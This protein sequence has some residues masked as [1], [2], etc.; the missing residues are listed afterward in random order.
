MGVPRLFPYICQTFPNSVKGVLQHDTAMTIDNLYIDANPIIHVECQHVYNY[1]PNKRLLQPYTDLSSSEKQLLVY[2]RIFNAIIKLVNIVTPT[3]ILFIAIDGTAPVS[4]QNQQRQRRFIATYNKNVTTE[5]TPVCLSPGTI[6]MHNLTQYINYKIRKY[7]NHQY[8]L[9][10]GLIVYFSSSQV[11]GEGEHKIMNF[12]RD[13]QFDANTSHCFY[14]PDADLIMLTLSVHVPIIYL[15]RPNTNGYHPAGIYCDYHIVNMSSIRNELHT[16]LYT[17]EFIEHNLKSKSQDELNITSNDFILIGLFVGND[18]LP[19]IKMFYYLESGIQFMLDAHKDIVKAQYPGL[20]YMMDNKYMINMHKFRLFVEFLSL[21]E[22]D[23]LTEQINIPILDEKYYDTLL[24]DHVD[25]R[26]DARINTIQDLSHIQITPNMQ[27]NYASYRTAYYKKAG[28]EN[29]DEIKKMCQEYLKGIVWVFDYYTNTIPSW[30]WY[31]PYHY[32][33]LMQDFVNVLK[34]KYTHEFELGQ[35]SIPFVQLLSILPKNCIHLLPKTFNKVVNDE[36]FVSHKYYS[37]ELKMDYE[38]KI[39]EYQG[40]C[41]LS[42]V[43]RQIINNV[44]DKYKGKKI[45]KRN[46]LGKLAKF[47]KRQQYKKFTSVY[48]N[49]GKCFVK[50]IEE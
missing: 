7:L 8:S 4:K 9:N 34:S 5:F 3:K 27:L 17:H 37:D 29:E 44:Y 1:G 33:P 35:P 40:I 23:Y 47:S 26:I 38:G 25:Y 12:I 15:L 43:D 48:G 50:R 49:I 11:P 46:E 18:F 16:I 21:Y 28:V 14:G 32:A 42:F 13:K 45:Y 22:N 6:F 30:D 20:T 19:P 39:K 10:S 2:E 24:H 36:W 31:Y 41:L